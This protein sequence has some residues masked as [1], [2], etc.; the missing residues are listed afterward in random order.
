MNK[1]L[2][3]LKETIAD[4]RDDFKDNVLVNSKDIVEV[5]EG[6]WT[7]LR[8][9]VGNDII[10]GDGD[11]YQLSWLRESLKKHGWSSKLDINNQKGMEIHMNF[12]NSGDANFIVKGGNHRL[13]IMAHDNL[14][15]DIPVVLCGKKND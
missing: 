5:S 14:D 12:D 8:N 13:A 6:P 10:E 11:T 4:E 9:I 2:E 7:D 1:L 15:I 3:I